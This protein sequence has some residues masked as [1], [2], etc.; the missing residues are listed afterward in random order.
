MC[1]CGGGCPIKTSSLVVDA[2]IPKLKR[3]R[4]DHEFKDNLIFSHE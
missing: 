3:L 1:V 2:V 4:Q